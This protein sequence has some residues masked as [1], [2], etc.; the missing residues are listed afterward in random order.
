MADQA[1]K[2]EP[3]AT[4]DLTDNEGGL[5]AVILRQQP[6]TTYQI[7]KIYERSPASSIN[8]SKGSV[9]PLVERLIKR[10]LVTTEASAQGKRTAQLLSCTEAG[11]VAVREWV[12]SIRLPHVLLDDPLR[13]KVMSFDLLSRDEQL[14]WIVEMKELVETKKRQVEEFHREH[15]L[16]YEPVIYANAMGHLRARMEWLDELLRF[17]VKG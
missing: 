6:L 3:N 1:G 4:S 17:I 9:Y 16:A 10:G 11:R 5:L 15:E 7:V 14:Q 2:I 8:E 12:R 13:S